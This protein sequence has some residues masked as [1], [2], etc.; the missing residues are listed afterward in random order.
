MHGDR[1]NRC[2]RHLKIVHMTT[3]RS[4]QRWVPSTTSTCR[5]H[6]QQISYTVLKVPASPAINHNANCRTQVKDVSGYILK[7]GH[8]K[9]NRRI[10]CN[11]TSTKN[12]CQKYEEGCPIPVVKLVVSDAVSEACSLRIVHHILIYDPTMMQTE[13]R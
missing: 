2:N 9:I 11:W 3:S 13:G 6:S 7:D 12:K 5:S 8:V 10:D 4:T 1:S